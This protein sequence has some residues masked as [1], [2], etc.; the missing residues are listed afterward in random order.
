MTPRFTGIIA[1]TGEGLLDFERNRNCMEQQMTTTCHIEKIGTSTTSTL[2]LEDVVVVESHIQAYIW[3]DEVEQPLEIPFICSPNQVRELVVGHMIT[4]GY[5]SSLA[6]IHKIDVLQE[7]ER[8]DV[9]ARLN[10][11]EEK[12]KVQQ[13]VLQKVPISYELIGM[14]ARVTLES[15]TLFQKT[16]A[17][18]IA[19]LW[20]GEEEFITYSDIGRHNAID[21]V[22]GKAVLE[23]VNLGKM[24]LFTSGRIPYH[25]VRKSIVA[26]I[27]ILASR[28]APTDQSI[29][30]ARKHNLTLLGFVRGTTINY[31]Q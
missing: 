9:W 25:M 14:Q 8:I 20:I 29:L 15:S 19:S 26:G 16:G 21:K 5:I 4:E 12:E 22:V 7:C 23:G 6:Q 17:L 1:H 11:Q 10:T 28:S 13:K 30:L 18:H 2:Q 31:Y 3:D 24:T 27:P